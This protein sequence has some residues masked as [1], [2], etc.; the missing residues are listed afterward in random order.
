MTKYFI[1]ALLSFLLIGKMSAQIKNCDLSI[2]TM[3]PGDME[4]IPSGDTAQVDFS[5]LN[6][7]PDAL[8][9]GDT[10]RY[11]IFAFSAYY[12]LSETLE[13]GNSVDIPSPG[14]FY[15]TSSE[16][17]TV[18]F[19][20]RVLPITSQF[21][22]ADSTNNQLCHTFVLSGTG[23]T[24]VKSLAERGNNISLYPNPCS[25]ELH[26]AISD[27]SGPNL[28]I[29]VYDLSGR[30]I[31]KNESLNTNIPIDVSKWVKG[32]YFVKIASLDAQFV[33]NIVVN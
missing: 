14:S 22:D 3:A 15:N 11:Q 9:A 17:D 30:I 25:N 8:E 31:L 33:K 12:V 27:Y 32:M 2:N 4:I 1:T 5:I 28:S 18:E 6:N 19:C 21:L 10:L 20:I 29:E 7:G 24:N 23:S 26:I 16:P 13:M